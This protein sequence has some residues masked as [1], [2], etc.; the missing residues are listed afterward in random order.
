MKYNTQE[1]VFGLLLFYSPSPGNRDFRHGIRGRNKLDMDKGDVR[2]DPA[3]KEDNRK[4][5]CKVS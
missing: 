4:N 5:D 1:A 3:R 2:N